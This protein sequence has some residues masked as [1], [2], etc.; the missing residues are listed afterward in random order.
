[1][2]T[3]IT[4]GTDHA[5]LYPALGTRLSEGYVAIDL[6]GYEQN[7][8]ELFHALFG[9]RF[10]FDYPD[11]PD[12][13]Y[14]KGEIARIVLINEEQRARIVDAIRDIEDSR[15]ADSMEDVFTARDTAEDLL[16]ELIGGTR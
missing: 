3:Y 12:Y 9:N 6:P 11:R 2:T 7:E 13:P 4:F 1:M 5:D 10:A 15:G 14:R 16:V 8:R